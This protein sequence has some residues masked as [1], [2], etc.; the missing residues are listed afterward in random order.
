MASG[1]YDIGASLSSSSTS[2]VNL[3]SAFSVIGGGGSNATMAPPGSSKAATKPA[4]LALYFLA[5]ATV[6]I[7]LWLFFGRRRR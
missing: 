1:G 6:L 3:N 2:G 4:T 7:G 5:A